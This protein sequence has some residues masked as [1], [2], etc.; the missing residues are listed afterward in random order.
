MN[1]QKIYENGNT[2]SILLNDFFVFNIDTTNSF[3]YIKKQKYYESKNLK[4]NTDILICQEPNI[5]LNIKY[6]NESIF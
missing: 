3:V 2:I 6:K 1:I 5:N 4:S